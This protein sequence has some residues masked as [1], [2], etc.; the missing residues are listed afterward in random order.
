M[1]TYKQQLDNAML[2]LQ[3]LIDEEFEY[4]E[5]IQDAFNALACALDDA[6]AE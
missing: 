4:N 1:L 6:V 3:T 5:S 2:Q